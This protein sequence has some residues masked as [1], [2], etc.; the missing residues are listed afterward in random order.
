MAESQQHVV[1]AGNPT[2]C[3]DR[4]TS[5][6]QATCRQS[7]AERVGFPTVEAEE[8]AQRVELKALKVKES[9]EPHDL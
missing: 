3:C 5:L 7:L 4:W 8:A 6:A 2:T 1:D 9:P